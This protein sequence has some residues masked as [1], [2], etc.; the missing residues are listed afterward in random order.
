MGFAEGGKVKFDKNGSN[1]SLE[2]IVAR[3]KTPNTAP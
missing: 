2:F 3:F 1:L